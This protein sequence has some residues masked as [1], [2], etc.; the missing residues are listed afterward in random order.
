MVV[1]SVACS[2]IELVPTVI[3]PTVPWWIQMVGCQCS[4]FLYRAGANCNKTYCTVAD[5][6]SVVSVSPVP[7]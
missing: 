3:R 2:S 7:L 5:T 6:D 4:L 1:V